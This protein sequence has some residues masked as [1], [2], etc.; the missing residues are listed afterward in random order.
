MHKQDGGSYL[1]GHG[2]LRKLAFCEVLLCLGH[3][4]GVQ[5]LLVLFPE[6]DVHLG[7]VRKDVKLVRPNAVGTQGRCQVL[8]D[9]RLYALSFDDGDAPAAHGDHNIAFAGQAA[10]QLHVPDA[11]GDRRRHHLPPPAALRVFP[12]RWPVG[13][14]HDVVIPGLTSVIPGLTGNLLVIRPYRLGGVPEGR[15]IGLHF[16]TGNQ[17]NYLAVQGMFGQ[18]AVHA[19]LDEIGNGTLR[20][21]AAK[22]HGLGGQAIFLFAGL[23]P[24]QAVSYLRTIAMADNQVVPF[25]QERHQVL[26]GALHIFQLFGEGA[27]LARAQ[28]RV[29]PESNHSKFG[30]ISLF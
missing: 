9:D 24:Q 20:F 4:E 26:A 14:G 1:G 7:H 11:D 30:H 15:I 21:R 28:Q 17:R 3:R 23:V 12:V 22:I 13:A 29:A 25:F 10:H 16:Y 2:A 19:T 5:R 8:V 18:H 27:L 6:V